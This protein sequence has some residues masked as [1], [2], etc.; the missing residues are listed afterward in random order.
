MP[1]KLPERLIVCDQCG[2]QFLWDYRKRKRRRF[3]SVACFRAHPVAFNRQH[4]ESRA[5]SKGASPEWNAWQGMI[6]RCRDTKRRPYHGGKGIKVCSRWL[7]YDNFLSDMGR[8]PS[9][10]HSLDRVDNNRD[11]G[12]DNCRWATTSEQNANRRH[13]P[14]YMKCWLHS[15]G[16]LEGL[17]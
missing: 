14:I 2:T 9:P 1:V 6:D 7:S 8:K 16:M 12:P 5:S 4:G 11:Y 15:A 10:K 13:R 3:C 17:I